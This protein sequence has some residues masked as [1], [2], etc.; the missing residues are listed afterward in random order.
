LNQRERL[1]KVL[2]KEQTDRKPF[3]CPG[4]MMTMITTDVMESSGC[5][6]P[7]A[8]GSAEKMA[9]LTLAAHR[10]AGV[11]NLG[12]PF[13]MTV[14]AEA[15]GAKVDLGTRES[16]P[17]VISYAVNTLEELDKLV[18][19]DVNKGRAKVCT[20][21]IRILK[22]KAPEAPIIANVTGPISLATSLIDPLIYYRAIKK[23]KAAAH[24]LTHT[25][26]ENLI[27]FGR[28]MLHAGAD[29]ICIADPSAT[30]EIIGRK[31]FEEFVL[32][33]MNR[34]IDRFRSEFNAPSIVHIC[35]NV[36]TL[37]SALAGIASEAISVDSMVSIALLKQMTGQHIAMGN[38][39]TYLL[40]QGNADAV[41]KSAMACLT[42]GVDIL[43]PACGISPKTPLKNVRSLLQAALQ[44]GRRNLR[45]DESGN[46]D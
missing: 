13:C 10:F 32:P 22:G 7:E 5:F 29:L 21:A 19:L 18:P 38:V 17:K 36:R 15:M 20:D 30:G 41:L 12:V 37:G 33:S 3:I 31:A 9:I 6:W 40:A 27:T 25:V 2:R 39:S 42:R 1:V 16:E 35:G 23:K 8:H 43:A 44:M 24:R 34:M 46:R 45:A 11:E 4:G 28:A 26:T 14:E